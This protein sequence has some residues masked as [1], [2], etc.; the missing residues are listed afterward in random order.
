MATPK[1]PRRRIDPDEG[2]AALH[3]WSSGQREAELHPG[4]LALAQDATSGIERATLATAV[5]FTLEELASRAP[6]QALEVRVPP[7]GATQCIEGPAHRRGTPPA[8]V[9]VSPDVWLGL[10]T[11]R[12]SWADAVAAGEVDA[13]GERS[14]LSAHLPIDVL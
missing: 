8:V 6:G 9:E 7:F 3:M 11:G 10:V 2:R 5:R 12:V 14:D 4:G 13:S 1:T